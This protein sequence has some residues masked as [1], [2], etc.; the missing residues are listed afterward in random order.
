MAEDAVDEILRNLGAEA[1]ERAEA[2][3]HQSGVQ[4]DHF[5]AALEAV[6]DVEALV[7]RGSARRRHD[8]A[9]NLFDQD[10]V[11]APGAPAGEDHP[12]PCLS[13]APWVRHRHAI[14]QVKSFSSKRRETMRPIDSVRAR[15][16]AA[17]AG[18]LALAATLGGCIGYNG[19]FD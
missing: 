15:R 10:A 3:H 13:L 2:A 18:V 11:G 14:W 12:T 5:E 1:A 17:L 8:L 16:L 4:S 7:K 9:V 6:G 19:D